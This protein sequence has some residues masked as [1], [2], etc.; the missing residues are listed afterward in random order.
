MPAA[1]LLPTSPSHAFRSALW[2]RAQSAVALGWSTCLPAA[3]VL[4]FA[5]A[6]AYMGGPAWQQ[7]PSCGLLAL[8]QS[9][10]VQADAVRHTCNRSAWEAE[11]GES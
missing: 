6:P 9:R 8:S 10:K 7:D 5:L 2:A 4:S 1:V 11:A 3:Q